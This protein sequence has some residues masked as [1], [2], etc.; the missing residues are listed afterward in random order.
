MRAWGSPTWLRYSTKDQ[1]RPQPRRTFASIFAPKWP[2]HHDFEA[3]C[4]DSRVDPRAAQRL[5]SPELNPG[6]T[7]DLR[8]CA[9]VEEF[10]G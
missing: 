3:F 7:W 10:N 2:I 6:P 9:F 5:Q 4:A 8:T 1:C